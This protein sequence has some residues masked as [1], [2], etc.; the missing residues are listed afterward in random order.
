MN[1]PHTQ[2]T[3]RIWDL[4]TRLFHWL[5]M[6]SVAGLIMTGELAGDAMFFHFWFGYAVLT[7]VLFRLVT[8]CQLHSKSVCIEALHPRDPD[9]ASHTSRRTQPNWGIVCRLDVAF[10]VCA[11]HH[12]FHER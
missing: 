2:P 1:T 12:W 4:P 8:F 7:L 10:V 11:S 3:V 9:P 6:L 5:L